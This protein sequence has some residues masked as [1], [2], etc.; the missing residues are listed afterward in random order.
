MGMLCTREELVNSLLESY[1]GYYDIRRCEEGEAP[2]VAECAFHVH[3]AKYVLVKK[4][5]LWEANC[6]EYLYLFSVPVLTE[7]IYCQCR[8]Y[9]Y[10]HGMQLVKPEK[11]HMYTYLTAVIVADSSE[12]QACKLLKRCHIHKS[13]QFSL[14]GWMDFHT[15]LI[16]RESESVYTNSA[17]RENAKFLK[18]KVR[19]VNKRKKEQ[20]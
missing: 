12:K 18:K 6:H 2:L 10:E 4:A 9:V 3:S 5:T 15:A 1:Q 8:D 11:D 13:F 17:G 14:R 7:E 16:D 20:A 19:Q